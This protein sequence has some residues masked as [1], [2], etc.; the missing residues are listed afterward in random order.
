MPT[1]YIVRMPVLT[2][3][4][5]PEK[6]RKIFVR[7]EQIFRQLNLENRSLQ[8]RV[9]GANVG[10]YVRI[11][12]VRPNGAVRKLQIE[13][14]KQVFPEY[15]S[16]LPG[17]QPGQTLELV[18]GEEQIAVHIQAVRQMVQHP[19]TDETVAALGLP[20]VATMA[21]YRAKFLQDHG[22]ELADK[23]FRA[24]QGKLLEQVLG[25]MEVALEKEELDQY[26]RRQREMLQNISGDVDARVLRA[27]G[28]DG[29]KTLEECYRL[30]YEDNRRNYIL[31]LWGKALAE[32]NV[33]PTEEEYSQALE[34][35]CMAFNTD[36]AQV[37]RDGLREEVTRSFYMRHALSVLQDYYRSIVNIS[38]EQIPE[39]PL[40]G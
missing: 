26:D 40:K 2:A 20:G 17:C 15:E 22:Q 21:D 19:V 33:A 13:L 11:E 8:D 35:Y 14:G 10:D 28:G 3:L 7:D 27:Y 16:I 30:F 25:M 36:E 12:A 24:L 18:L 29:E 31:W 37:E 39:K 4:E 32:K 9:D 6:Q 34:F 23:L 5:I 1:S 38:A